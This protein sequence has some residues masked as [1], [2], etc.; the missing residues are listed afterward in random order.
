MGLKIVNELDIFQ[1]YKVETIA[2][3][4]RSKR[5]KPIRKIHTTEISW[6]SMSLISVIMYVFIFYIN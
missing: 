5:K 4:A 6:K 3:Q 1:T 2:L